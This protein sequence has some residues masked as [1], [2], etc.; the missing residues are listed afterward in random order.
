MRRTSVVRP[1][2]KALK[3]ESMLGVDT[4]DTKP[5]LRP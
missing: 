5:Y 3:G 2:R 1:L 4:G